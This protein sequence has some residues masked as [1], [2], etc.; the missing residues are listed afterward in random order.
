[1]RR[2]DPDEVEVSEDPGK[3]DGETPADGDAEVGENHNREDGQGDAANLRTKAAILRNTH[4]NKL[5]MDHGSGPSWI[6][7]T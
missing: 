2:A 3:A 4:H 1:M 5:S 7:G 6:C